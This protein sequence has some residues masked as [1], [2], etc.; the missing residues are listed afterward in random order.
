MLSFFR[1]KQAASNAFFRQATASK[2]NRTKKSI[3][4]EKRRSVVKLSWYMLKL[5]PSWSMFE[6]IKHNFISHA[7][8][9]NRRRVQINEPPIRLQWTGYFLARFSTFRNIFRVCCFPDFDC[10]FCLELIPTIY[11]ILNVFFFNSLVK[12]K[13]AF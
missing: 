10:Q 8:R 5:C 13:F 4:D 6:A 2:I 11:E 7:A 12:K 3:P 9:V 1:S